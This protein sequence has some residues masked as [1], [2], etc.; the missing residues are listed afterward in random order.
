MT[1]LRDV[2]RKIQR[3]PIAKTTTFSAT[4]IVAGLLV[5]AVSGDIQEKGQTKW[6]KLPQSKSLYGLAALTGFVYL[7]FRFS[8]DESGILPES[9]LSP[10]EVE[11]YNNPDYIRAYI[12]REN[13]SALA[14][15]AR[16]DIYHGNYESLR[17]MN[18]FIESIDSF[19]E[20]P[21]LNESAEYPPNSPPS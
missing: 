5:N 9:P 14:E 1:S 17:D 10:I 19:N 6:E 12:I 4:V 16:S 20:S 3:S 2:W 13:L 11:N 15:K 18:E 21:I 8:S 7:G